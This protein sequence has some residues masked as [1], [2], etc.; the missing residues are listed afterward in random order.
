MALWL[1][2]TEPSA[3]SLDDLERD[4]TT[5]WDGI[6]NSLALKHLAAME[7]GDGVLVYHTGEERRIVGLARVA[8]AAGGAPPRVELAFDRRLPRP[9]TLAAI[10]ARPEFSAFPLV[11]MGRLSVMPVTRAE[12]DALLALCH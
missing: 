8:A 5:V 4:G 11:R 7:P 1:V 9:L 6:G 2:K 10:K 3:Y 12:W